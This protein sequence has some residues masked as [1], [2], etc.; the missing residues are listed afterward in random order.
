MSTDSFAPISRAA[1]P[2]IQS[3]P[4]SPKGAPPKKNEIVNHICTLLNIHRNCQ[5]FLY[6]RLLHFVPENKVYVYFQQRRNPTGNGF[7]EQQRIGWVD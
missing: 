5:L 6:G 3:M 2:V 4:L 7:N 1:G